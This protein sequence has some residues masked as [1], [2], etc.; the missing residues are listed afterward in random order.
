MKIETLAL[1]VETHVPASGAGAE[2]SS[3]RSLPQR[4]VSVLLLIACLLAGWSVIDG[5]IWSLGRVTTT[6]CEEEALFPIWKFAK[7]QSVYGN[8]VAIPFSVSYFNWL[9]FSIYGGTAKVFFALFHLDDGSLPVIARLVTLGFALASIGILYAL[10]GK[11]IPQTFAGSRVVRVAYSIF[12]IVNPLTGSWLFTARPDVA[13]L[14]CELA[15]LLWALRY[16]ESRRITH[17][18]GAA[19]AGYAAWSFKQNFVHL[20]GGLCVFHALR[21]DWRAL[22]LVVLA[23]IGLVG[24][25]LLAGGRD[26]RHALIG[27]QLNCA[28]DG[29]VGWQL[30]QR[31]AG[32]MP[33]LV[34]IGVGFVLVGLWRKRW[35]VSRESDLLAAT[36]IVALGIGFLGASKQGAD[37]NY[38]IP[39]SIFGTL[40][41]LCLFHAKK[42]STLEANK[43]SAI[44]RWAIMAM[45]GLGILGGL[46]PQ[47]RKAT[48]QVAGLF[49][50]RDK[51]P[52]NQSAP[53]VSDQIAL[54]KR[55]LKELPAPVF[56]ADR[57]CNLPWIQTKAP[58]FVYS[59]TYLLD[60]KAGVNFEQGG[61]GGLIEQ[62]Y[63]ETVVVAERNCACESSAFE[64]GPCSH[65]TMNH[66]PVVKDGNVPSLDGGQMRHYR[67]AFRDGWFTYYLKQ[68][69]LKTE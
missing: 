5:W 30:F 52:G 43:L 7:G 61:I 17:L 23:T 24:A 29:A 1:S 56:V 12:L 27:S 34:A 21:R 45:F 38:F 46:A 13:A 48:T 14:A 36:G 62:G 40:W 64:Q 4:I 67:L 37:I 20:L 65:I 19:I 54:L 8:T 10:L 51:S 41:G 58:H 68:K 63:F 31:V 32:L 50:T 25:T 49:A 42:E 33:Q 28:V 15:G 53:A 44:V 55:H 66:L 22:G 26:F 6:G 57:A 11:L 39:T 47:I 60:R 3:P 59:F 2:T 9:F 18:L 69:P 16:S 35:P